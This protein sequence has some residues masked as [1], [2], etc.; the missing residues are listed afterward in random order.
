MRETR[1]EVEAARPRLPKPDETPFLYRQFE[2]QAHALEE[3]LHELLEEGKSEKEKKPGLLGRMFG[4]GKKT[5]QRHADLEGNSWTIPVPE[6]IGFLSNA[7]KTGMLWVD[8]EQEQFVIEIKKGQLIRAIGNGTPIGL[9]LGELLV[10]QGSIPPGTVDDYVLQAR[11]EGM[12]LGGFL[13][14]RGHVREEDVKSALSRQVQSLFDR[15]LEI[16]NAV[17]RFQEGVDIEDAEELQLNVTHLLL[18]SARQLD[19]SSMPSLLDELAKECES[20]AA[21]VETEEEE[22]EDASS[23]EEPESDSEA[24]AAEALDAAEEPADEEGEESS[25]AQVGRKRRRKRR[26]G[27]AA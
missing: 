2:E 14:A 21:R 5:K 6:L 3:T 25:E 18:E 19:E 10:E 26:R 13:I 16:G 17:Y 12:S 15:L 23:D 4:R 24:E 1:L 22:D 7:R 9:R 11:R 20:P 27:K 8:A